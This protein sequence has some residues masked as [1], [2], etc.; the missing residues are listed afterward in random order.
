[1]LYLQTP[2]LPGLVMEE[3]VDKNRSNKFTIIE[4][5]RHFG[6]FHLA[7][8]VITRLVMVRIVI[9]ITFILAILDIF[10]LVILVMFILIIFILVILVMF[11]VRQEMST[12]GEPVTRE[13]S[14]LELCSLT[15]AY[16]VELY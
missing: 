9:L 5:H 13:G 3:D 6:H 1:M 15:G 11:R 7:I 16:E 10:I 4:V 2:G 8:I 14:I 12:L